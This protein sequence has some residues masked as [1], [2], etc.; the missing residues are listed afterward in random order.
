MKIINLTENSR[1]YTSNAYLV[2][3]SWNAI[4][5]VNT[6]VDVGRDDTAIEKIE[7]ISTG[8]GKRRVERVVLTHSHYDHVGI[9]PLVQDAFNPEVYA[10]SK[11]MK[12]VDRILKDGD[13]LKFGDRLFQAV[14]TPGHS[15]DSVCFY[16][17]AEGILFTGDTPIPVR[18]PGGVY[19]SGF[20]NAIEMFARADIKAIFPGHGPPVRKE[21]NLLIRT[22][23]ENISQSK[24]DR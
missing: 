11:F 3:G 24:Q 18:S 5:D 17:E 6:L 22:T 13:T 14:F 23:L 20:V 19:E 15:S 10:S 12:G 9:L 21:C 1:I 4:A 8:V 2:L 7:E 16:C